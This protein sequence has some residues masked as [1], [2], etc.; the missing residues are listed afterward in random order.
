MGSAPNPEK[1]S[2]LQLDAMPEFNV[3]ILAR[4]ARL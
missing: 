2:L 4:S 1:A 3:N